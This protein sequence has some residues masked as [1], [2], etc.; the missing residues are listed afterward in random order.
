MLCN[1]FAV[2]EGVG[3]ISPPVLFSYRHCQKQLLPAGFL[4]A[5]ATAGRYR[6]LWCIF[7]QYY[8]LEL[9]VNQY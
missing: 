4:T 7:L 3:T 1:L 8:F 6:I 2:A 5:A 9:W